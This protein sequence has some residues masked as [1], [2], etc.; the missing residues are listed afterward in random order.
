MREGRTTMRCTGRYG[1]INCRQYPGDQ[2]FRWEPRGVH[3]A[4]V[5]SQPICGLVIELA[6][7]E[8]LAESHLTQYMNMTI[9][10]RRHQDTYMLRTSAD[11]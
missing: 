8:L 10:K 2:S 3:R 11:D 7:R 1:R 5:I 9:N 4:P 6:L